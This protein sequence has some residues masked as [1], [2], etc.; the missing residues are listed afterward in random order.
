M[1][2]QLV[3]LFTKR[4]FFSQC[5]CLA[6]I[7]V[8]KKSIFFYLKYLLSWFTCFLTA[9]HQKQSKKYMASLNISLF[10]YANAIMKVEVSKM[11]K[12]AHAF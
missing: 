1:N 4:R 8:F 2:A 10:T 5:T 7:P 12:Y 3:Y 11:P 6:D 9:V